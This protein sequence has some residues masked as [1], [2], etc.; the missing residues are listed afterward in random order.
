M[1][2]VDEEGGMLEDLHIGHFY[3]YILVPVDEVGNAD[4]LSRPENTRGIRMDEMY[5]DYHPEPPE[6]EPPA[7]PEFLFFGPSPWYGQLQEDLSNPHNSMAWMAAFA[8]IMVNLLMLPALVNKIRGMK[9]RVDRA[10]RQA[11]RNKQ[12]M[13]A[14]DL[15]DDFDDFFG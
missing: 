7:P 10:K 11:A 9:R 13:A 6:P 15:A 1:I 8:F 12:M 5:W 14:D 2:W 3:N 4:Y